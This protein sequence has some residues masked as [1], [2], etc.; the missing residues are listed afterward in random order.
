MFRFGPRVPSLSAPHASVSSLFPGRLPAY[1]RAVAYGGERSAKPLG[2][3]AVHAADATTRED[4]KKPSDC[5]G[6]SSLKMRS[7]E[8]RE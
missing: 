1:M 8:Y 7:E 5:E 3:V 2:T 6:D 4:E